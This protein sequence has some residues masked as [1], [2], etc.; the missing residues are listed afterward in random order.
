MV[1]R[2]SSSRDIEQLIADLREGG[3]AREAAVARLRVIGSRADERLASFMA[4][5]ASADART[6]ALRALEG[7]EE[8]RAR[9]IARAACDD[10]DPAV[11][12]AAIAVL[13][14]WVARESG[15]EV[16]D[17]LSG[18]ALDPHRDSGVRLAALD[19]LAELPPD[20]VR[21]LLQ[22]MPSSL[23]PDPN[24][25]DALDAIDDPLA[26]SAWIAD[27]REAPL[28]SLH[29]AVA[30]IR[31]QEQ[32]DPPTRIRE[33]WIIARGAAHAA[34]ADRGSRVALYDLRESF[35][36]AKTPLPLDFLSA[37]STLGDATCLEPLARAWFATPTDSWWR[38]RLREAAADVIA[39]GKLTGRHQ[40]LKRV[41]AKYPDFV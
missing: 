16:L 25:A 5:D 26:M 34:L 30:R 4:S 1:I 14:V 3:N 19:A 17:A 9:Q 36:S 22:G 40:A 37:M 29:E 35:D 24:A 21:P 8:T 18:I 39:R 32:Q 15:T 27:H 10:T 7:R 31:E 41:R 12:I 6:A 23:R 13:R 38:E 2:S 11:V 20:I 28:S 33:A